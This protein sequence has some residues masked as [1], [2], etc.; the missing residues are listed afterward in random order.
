MANA[1]ATGAF[2]AY[3]NT[4]LERVD[5][6]TASWGEQTLAQCHRSGPCPRA[7]S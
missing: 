6:N 5:A 2:M 3:V 7:A 1:M 4:V